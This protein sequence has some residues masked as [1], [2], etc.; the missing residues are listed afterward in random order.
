MSITALELFGEEA[1]KRRT[2]S[3]TELD[4]APIRSL[5]GNAKIKQMFEKTPFE[6]RFVVGHMPSV[7]DDPNSTS[8][9]TTKE[10]IIADIANRQKVEAPNSIQIIYT[11]NAASKSN[12]V[13]FTAWILAHR[14]GH[15]NL[16]YRNSCVNGDHTCSNENVFAA[17]QKIV[18]Q[19]CTPAYNVKPQHTVT[20]QL[21]SDDMLSN[22]VGSS[23]M[24]NDGD[25][26]RF[27][28][29]PFVIGRE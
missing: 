23:C 12:Y 26:W 22:S 4:V 6:F 20:G 21:Y 17:I 5:A 28:M 18:L 11:N 19:H 1:M 15:M 29:M 25:P 14:I 8:R 16:M 13:P 9:R 3:V 24:Y 2:S 10:K 7:V 27:L